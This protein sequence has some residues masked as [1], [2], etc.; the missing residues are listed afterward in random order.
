MEEEALGLHGAALLL[1]D[2]LLDPPHGGQVPDLDGE[3]ATLRRLERHLH[4]A[5]FACVICENVRL[6]IYILFIH[7]I[8]ICIAHPSFIL[9][10]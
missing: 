5:R 7:T 3:S 2:V 1:Q 6:G 4:R 8:H 10:T 9:I